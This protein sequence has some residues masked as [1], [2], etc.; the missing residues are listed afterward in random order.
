MAAALAA[1]GGGGSNNANSAVDAGGVC[2]TFANPGILR[3]TTLSPAMGSSVV[4]GNVVHRFVVENA[5]A[6]FTQF[7]LK[8]GPGHTAG[9]STPAEPTITVTPSGPSGSTLLYQVT[10]DAWSQAPGHVELVASNGYETSKKCSWIFPSPL[11]SY[12]LAP[13][14][15]GGVSGEAGGATDGGGTGSVMDS[16]AAIDLASALDA[17]DEIDASVD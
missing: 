13:A 1:C 14:L 5:P 2:G 9:L 10:V 12:D 16:P 7:T 17:P 11:F 3:S 4:N 8:Y 15:D 6:V